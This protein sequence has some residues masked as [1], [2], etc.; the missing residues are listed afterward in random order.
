MYEINSNFNSLPISKR[1]GEHF[2]LYFDGSA[3]KIYIDYIKKISEK[4]YISVH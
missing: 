2:I 3:K 4:N 1:G